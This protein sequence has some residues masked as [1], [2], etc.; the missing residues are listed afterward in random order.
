MNTKKEIVDKTYYIL[1]EDQ[2]ST[3]FDKE[4]TVTPKIN[5]T[6][7]QICRCNVTNILT[8]QKI[9]GG[10][11]DFL[12]EDKTIIIPRTKKSLNAI[13]VNST[14]IQLDNLDW[15]PER[16]YLEIN[17]NIISY[18]WLDTTDWAVIQVNGINGDHAVNSDVHFAYIFPESI[19]KPSDFFDVEYEEILKFIDFR[20]KRPDYF[21]CYTIKPYKWKKVAIF[22]NMDNSPILISYTKKLEPM[23]SDED[24]CGLPDDYGVKIVPYIVA[25][26]LLIDTSEVQKAERLLAIWYAELEDMYSYYATPTKQFRKKIKTTPLNHTLY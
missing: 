2:S 9:R 8:G 10:I 19:M 1:G 11:L 12:Y 6:I 18:E 16:W 21:R 20:E 13:D 4:G 23:T 22:Y 5:T 14:Y 25:G 24:E 15:L 17:W 7:D 26:Q 3:V